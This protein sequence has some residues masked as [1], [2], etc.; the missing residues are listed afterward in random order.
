MRK[1]RVGL[2]AESEALDERLVASEVLVPEVLEQAA[3]LAYHDEESAAAMEVLLVDLHVLGELADARREDGDLD[4]RGAGVRL[5]R[6]VLFDDRLFLIL[7][8]HTY[9]SVPGLALPLFPPTQAC[10][11]DACPCRRSWVY[12]QKAAASGKPPRAP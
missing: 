9:H 2:V 7:L 12:Y 5:V 8:Y 11:G 10:C 6:L 1:N 4:F 3:A